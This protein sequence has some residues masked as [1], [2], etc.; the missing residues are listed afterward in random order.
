MASL[1]ILPM[2]FLWAPPACPPD[3]DCVSAPPKAFVNVKKKVV[4]KKTKVVVKT[5]PG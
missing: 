5:K 3:E 4:I 2:R 1:L